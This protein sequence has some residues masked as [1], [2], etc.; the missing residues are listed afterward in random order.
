MSDG[1][2]WSFVV[3]AVAGARVVVSAQHRGH[4][5]R[6]SAAVQCAERNPMLK[7]LLP[8]AVA[9][10]LACTAVSAAPVSAP[11]TSGIAAST[12]S[13]VVDVRDHRRAHRGHHRSHR[14]RG[15]SRSLSSRPPLSSRPVRL[16]PVLF[17]PVQL[18]QPRLRDR[19]TAVVLPVRP[20]FDVIRSCGARLQA[21]AAFF[22]M[23]A[24]RQLP[25]FQASAERV[26]CRPL[27][28]H[29]QGRDRSR[30][31]FELTKWNKR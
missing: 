31:E 22:C 1:N 3:V 11:T 7:Y 14:H 15:L 21:G 10:L 12:S 2:A 29:A 16:P 27:R 25:D 24:S 5:T 13:S 4:A 20:D 28:P 18:A 17:S 19:R 9:S 23:P 30:P 6:D 8:A 26:S